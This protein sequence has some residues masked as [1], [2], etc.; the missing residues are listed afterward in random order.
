VFTAV[1]VGCELIGTIGGPL[2]V[3]MHAGNLAFAL[4]LLAGLLLERQASR[5]T[6]LRLDHRWGWAAAGTLL[7]A[8]VVWNTAKAGSPLCS[9]SAFIQGHGV[10]HLLCAVSAWLL[11]QLYVSERLAQPAGR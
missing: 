9:P 4:A 1:L 6:G 7:V 5:R 11:F 8:F 10:W 2:P 3:I